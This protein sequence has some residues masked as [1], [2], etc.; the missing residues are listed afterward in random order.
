ML[1][2]SIVFTWP[3]TPQHHYSE[4]HVAIPYKPIYDYLDVVVPDT[5]FCGS[6]LASSEPGACSLSHWQL[7]QCC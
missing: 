5:V 7:L 4:S 3:W 6:T 2:L 1:R